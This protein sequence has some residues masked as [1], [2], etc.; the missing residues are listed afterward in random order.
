[1]SRNT[2]ANFTYKQPL[3]ASTLTRRRQDRQIFS[4]YL[5]Q[6]QALVQGNGSRIGLENGQPADGS[7]IPDLDE[8]RVFTTPAEAA[9]ILASTSIVSP[10]PRNYVLSCDNYTE[11]VLTPFTPNPFTFTVTGAGAGIVAFLFL[12]YGSPLEIQVKPVNS[13]STRTLVVPPGGTTSIVYAFLCNPFFIALDC[14]DT[15]PQGLSTA[16]PFAFGNFSG[17][18]MRL[19]LLR[20]PP[21]LPTAYSIANNEAYFPVP[22]YGWAAYSVACDSTEYGV[23]WDRTTSSDTYFRF[24]GYANGSLGL[25]TTSVLEADYYLANLYAC[26]SGFVFVY[27]SQTNSYD[28]ILVFVDSLTGTIRKTKSLTNISYLDTNIYHNSKNNTAVFVYMDNTNNYIKY[29]LYNFATLTYFEGTLNDSGVEVLYM[30]INTYDTENCI[31]FGIIQTDGTVLNYKVIDNSVLPTLVYS[32]N[33]SSNYSY[34]AFNHT[35]EY[36]VLFKTFNDGADYLDKVYY[37]DAS[38]NSKNISMLP[39]NIIMNDSLYGAYGNS[40]PYAFIWDYSTYKLYYF[41]FSKSAN[42]I[43]DEEIDLS[44]VFH[45][46]FVDQWN[47]L[48]DDSWYQVYQADSANQFFVLWFRLTDNTEIFYD[49]VHRKVVTTIAPSIYQRLGYFTFCF[50]GVAQIRRYSDNHRFI[51]IF[52]ADDKQSG[53]VPLY[54]QDGITPLTMSYGFYN[55]YNLVKATLLIY[56]LNSSNYVYVFVSLDGTYKSFDMTE[57]ISYYSHNTTGDGLFVLNSGAAY[58]WNNTTQ[59][60]IY[61]YGST[62]YVSTVGNYPLNSLQYLLA[63][64]NTWS[65]WGAPNPTP[66]SSGTL[67]ITPD[68]NIFAYNENPIGAICVEQTSSGIY[69]R[70][71]LYEEPGGPRVTSYDDTSVNGENYYFDYNPWTNNTLTIIFTLNTDSSQHAAYTYNRDADT[72]TVSKFTSQNISGNTSSYFPFTAYYY[73]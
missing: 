21:A 25:I 14:A 63:E 70:I 12:R 31:T 37:L 23:L 50:I 19:K 38:G 8:G 32:C 55:L 35:L 28:Y 1:M 6:S 22:S 41:D 47:L 26:R 61:V 54:R 2:S 29:V 24:G 60:F 58:L 53:I 13:T 68:R 57:D 39:S 56:R 67:D 17:D 34:A 59:T 64:D 62:N 42:L 48:G 49:V 65:L 11:Q 33:S 36:K 40:T 15:S 46:A 5:I 66:F 16:F 43:L 45:G 73:G 27:Q 4:S 30:N 51:S 44:T 69:I 10:Y 7:I 52:T 71:I 20:P 9:A 3:D 72:W 18:V